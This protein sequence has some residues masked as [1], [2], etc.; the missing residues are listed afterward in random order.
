MSKERILN[1]LEHHLLSM[2][3]NESEPLFILYADTIRDVE[4]A[5]LDLVLQALIKLVNLGFS[6][7]IL[8]NFGKK[9]T[10]ESLTFEDLE[11][12]FEG[13]TEEQ[14]KEYPSGDEYYF[15]TTDQGRIEEA[16]EVYNEYYKDLTYD[17]DKSWLK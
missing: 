14:K 6:K 10:C 12:R 7:C 8:I 15:E 1:R 5:T 16:K 11:K 3:G 2:Q 9:Q 13:L 17:S 4:G